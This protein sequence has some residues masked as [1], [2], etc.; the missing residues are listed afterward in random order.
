MFTTALHSLVET[1]GG[2]LEAQASGGSALATPLCA[3][4]APP[5][6]GLMLLNI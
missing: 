3:A 1:S 2:G 5:A 6:A 4:T